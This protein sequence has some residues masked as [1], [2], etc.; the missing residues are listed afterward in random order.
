VIFRFDLLLVLICYESISL[1][2]ADDRLDQL[3]KASFLLIGGF[4]RNIKKL[5]CAESLNNFP[6]FSHD[7][8]YHEFKL[9]SELVRCLSQPI[10]QVIE[11]KMDHFAQEIRLIMEDV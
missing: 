4:G 11:L 3:F 7:F 1:S 8:E 10:I 6:H 9:T 5:L 2:Q